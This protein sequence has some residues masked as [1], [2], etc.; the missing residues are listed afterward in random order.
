MK[1]RIARL[2]AL[3][4]IP[5]L[6]LAAV[7]AGAD[8]ARDLNWSGRVPAGATLTV[9]SINGNITADAARGTEAATVVAHATSKLGD[10]SKVRLQVKESARGVVVCAVTPYQEVSEDCTS[11][12]SIESVDRDHAIRI[13]FTVH[14]PRGAE[15]QARAVNGRIQIAP[16]SGRV[17]AK[18][19]NG[20]I[21]VA[22]AERIRAKTVN[23]SID[24]QIGDPRWSGDLAFATVNGSI[25]IVV[26][27]GA[28]FGV[29]ARTVN[30][31]IDAQAFGLESTGR[32]VG[33]RLDGTVGSSA[34]GRS[35]TL[36]TVNGSIALTPAGR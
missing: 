6:L 33:R 10:L 25:K 8:Q 7:P 13:D 4:I 17:D 3:P 23:G 5:L 22:S 26:P 19:V 36:K 29:S 18:T 21:S 1:L 32:F 15:F 12:H 30:G 11:S 9:D 20:S 14:V 28:S 24:A 2:G 35:L 31:A 34:A 27:S 16:L